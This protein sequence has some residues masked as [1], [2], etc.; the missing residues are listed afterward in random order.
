[1]QMG[2]CFNVHRDGIGATFSESTQESVRFNDHQVDVQR[3]G[4]HPRYRLNHRRTHCDIGHKAPVHHIYVDEIGARLLRARH[5][6]AQAPESP[7]LEL[8]ELS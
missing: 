3:D 4:S 5:L 2:T 6:F 7:P 1:M 8:K